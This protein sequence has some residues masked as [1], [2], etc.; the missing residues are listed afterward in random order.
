MYL[1][2]RPFNLKWGGGYGFLF[3]SEIFFWTTRQLDYFYFCRKFFFQ[4]ITLAYMTKTLN[5]ILFFLH[6][7][8]IFF[9][10][11]LGIRIFVQ[12]KTIPPP[13]FKLNGR[14]LLYAIQAVKH[15]HAVTSIKQSPVLKGPL[16]LVQSYKISFELNL[17]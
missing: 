12:K 8:R 15:A 13:P 16:F 1:R 3:R 7:N 14:S 6:Q 9:S 10:A 2:D 5:Q 11:T 4:N 17:F